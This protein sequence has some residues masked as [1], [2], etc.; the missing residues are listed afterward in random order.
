MIGGGRLFSCAR[1]LGASRAPAEFKSVGSFS[2]KD[3]RTSIL[4]FSL[5]SAVTNLNKRRAE[6]GTSAPPNRRGV[7]VEEEDKDV[8]VP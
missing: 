6:G 5:G 7:V 2:V 4:E 8:D 1:S 3:I